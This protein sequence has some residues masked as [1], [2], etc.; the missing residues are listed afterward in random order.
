M[1]SVTPTPKPKP[2]PKGKVLE[3]YAAE[4][5]LKARQGQSMQ[6][7]VN[8]LALP[9][10]NV[11]ITRQAVHLWLQARIRKLVK[12]Q[13]AFANTGVGAP[14]ENLIGTTS[15]AGETQSIDPKQGHRP[16]APAVEPALPP[17]RTRV[18]GPRPEPVHG[19]LKPGDDKPAPWDSSR[20]KKVD[21]GP[22]MPTD[23]GGA[24][25]PFPK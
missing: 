17:E 4:I 11:N 7:I 16:A 25:N 14:F 15:R 2:G 8:W 1:T 24:D 9:P 10:R 5:L 12:L 13:Q 6:D 22:E 18:L 21:F 3:P 23:S 20:P 19:N